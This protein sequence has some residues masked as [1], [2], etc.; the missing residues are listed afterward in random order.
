MRLLI[1]FIFSFLLSAAAMAGNDSNCY[2]LYM[3]AGAS[4]PG[5]FCLKYPDGVGEGRN[6]RVSLYGYTDTSRY[7]I[8]SFDATIGKSD[9]TSYGRFD[10]WT[11]FEING[12]GQRYSVSLVQFAG[13]NPPSFASIVIRN[14]QDGHAQTQIVDDSH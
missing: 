7:L 14:L 2:D 6:V 10:L 9:T 1:G 3:R 5:Q 12:Q 11:T 13:S 4:D 8:E